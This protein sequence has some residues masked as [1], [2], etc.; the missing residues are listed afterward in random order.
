MTELPRGEPL[1]LPASLVC[2]S[3]AP[4]RVVPVTIRRFDGSSY[5]VEAPEDAVEPGVDV[6]LDL[7]SQD[8]PIVRARTGTW[9]DGRLR[10]EVVTSQERDHRE[11]PRMAAGIHMR[12]RCMPASVTDAAC[13]SWMAGGA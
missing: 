3:T 11:F 6:V 13:A 2:T 4:V 8:L 7:A 1:E 9:Q 12:Y 5:E 10:L